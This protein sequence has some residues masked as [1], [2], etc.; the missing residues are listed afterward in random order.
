MDFDFEQDHPHH[1]QASV[2]PRNS[3]WLSA[4][5]QHH[6][7][8]NQ[9]QQQYTQHYQQQQHPFS[10]TNT[11]QHRNTVAGELFSTVN[12]NT[13]V[14]QFGGE[15]SDQFKREYNVPHKRRKTEMDEDDEEGDEEE[16]YSENND[17]E[18]DTSF[19]EEPSEQTLRQ[20]GRNQRQ[21][22]GRSRS[23]QS[24][25]PIHDMH[26]G[27]EE[28]SQDL[29]LRRPKPKSTSR[30][31]P[32]SKSKSSSSSSSL[33]SH[34]KHLVIP[35]IISGYLQLSFNICM[36]TLVLYFAAQFVRTIQRD[37][38]MKMEEYS[39]RKSNSL[40]TRS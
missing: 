20:R 34:E 7:H 38:T 8:Q 25:D 23:S 27:D 21:Q 1:A 6:N 19:E 26:T 3:I 24:R 28:I 35:Y 37:V 14:Y 12:N 9:N 2:D 39:T 40:Q 22:T 17:M 4:V 31:R 16:L 32:K 13:D 5:Q 18:M 33:P 29:S 30:S 11:Y 10:I 15:K 36:V